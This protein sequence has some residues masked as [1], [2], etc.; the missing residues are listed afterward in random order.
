[1]QTAKKD[2]PLLPTAMLTSEQTALYLNRIKDDVG[3]GSFEGLY[4][5]IENTHRWTYNFGYS[6][7][8]MRDG[9]YAYTP[10]PQYMTDLCRACLDALGLDPATAPDYDNVI[11]S[12]YGPGDRLEPHVDVDFS[13]PMTD[14]RPVNFYFGEDVIGL[15][16]EVDPEGRF[17]LADSNLTILEELDEKPG[18]AFLL[19]GPMR[20]EPYHHG[21][22]PIQKSRISVTFRTVQ[23]L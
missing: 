13:R 18:M 2:C 20:R 23:R 5:K 3:N 6:Y 7:F 12:L 22:S 17:F 1:M 15:V 21:V 8:Q 9:D 16:L 4:Q 14:G 11:L 19:T 10:I